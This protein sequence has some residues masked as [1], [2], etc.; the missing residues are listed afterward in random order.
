MGHGGEQVVATRQQLVGDP[1]Q[2]RTAVGWGP[3]CPLRLGGP[4]GCDHPVDVRDRR[5]H[6]RVHGCRA[7]AL[8]AA[9]PRLRSGQGQ[10]QV[11]LVDEPVGGKVGDPYRTP[12]PRT[13]QQ[14][15]PDGGTEAV[16][17]LVELDGPG[18]E[19]KE[20]S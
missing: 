12:R 1:V 10:V 9:Q 18:P 14:A 17:L 7:A 16:G 5:G 3:G 19:A 13:H 20:V 11:G 2:D 15:V 8:E 6:R 4:D